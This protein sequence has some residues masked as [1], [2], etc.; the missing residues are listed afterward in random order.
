VELALIAHERQLHGKL[1][2]DGLACTSRGTNYDA[3]SS[4]EMAHGLEL[5]II[6][7]KVKKALGIYLHSLDNSR[8]L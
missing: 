8:V 6:E 4:F 2:H 1:G 5:K 3:L 7:R